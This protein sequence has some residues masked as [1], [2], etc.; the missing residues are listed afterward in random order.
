M[1]AAKR[2]I[3]QYNATK[4][5]AEKTK[6]NALSVDVTA[7][8]EAF[9]VAL[10]NGLKRPKVRLPGFIISL[11]PASGANAGSLY[12][13][14]SDNVYLGKITDGKFFESSDCDN[15]QTKAMVEVLEDP[16]NAAKAY[17]QKTGRCSCCGRELT[18]HDSIEAGIGPICAENFGW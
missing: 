9:D 11:A 13:K 17:G 15:E 14:D 16:L 2:C 4:T 7:I 1:A 10:S 12:V 3:E 6:A 5:N 8:N 18:N